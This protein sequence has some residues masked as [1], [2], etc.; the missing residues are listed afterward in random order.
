MVFVF[1]KDPDVEAELVRT[2]QWGADAA[3]A[4]A[5][6]MLPD[7]PTDRLLPSLLRDLTGAPIPY[8]EPFPP[9]SRRPTL[10]Q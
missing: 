4:H 8:V 1:E 9:P 7:Q 3:R 10:R 5:L 2:A 6:V